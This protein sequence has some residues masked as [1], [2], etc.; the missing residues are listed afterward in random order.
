MKTSFSIVAIVGLLAV[1]GAGCFSGSRTSTSDPISQDLSASFDGMSP[2]DVAQNLNFAV[3]NAIVLRQDF[4]DASASIASRFGWGSSA[5]TTVVIKRFAPAVAAEVEWSR[6]TMV[7]DKGS[8]KDKPS[9]MSRVLTGTLTGG[10]LRDAHDLHLP[11]LWREGIYPAFGTSL[12]WLSQDEFENLDRTNVSTFRFGFFSSNVSTGLAP[13]PDVLKL[14]STLEADSTK[15]GIKDVTLTQADAPKVQK[16]RINGK[17]V[18]VEVR[19]ARNWFGTFVY[20]NNQQN[21]LILKV[22]LNKH[23]VGGKLGSFFDYHVTE[24]KTL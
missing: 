9:T 13:Y 20:L 6:E 10:V 1:F 4:S 23:L 14:L 24:I 3:G 5:T 19:E 15:P 11:S 16:L 17:E 2:H 8:K 22:E 7:A 12:L 18:D 21:P